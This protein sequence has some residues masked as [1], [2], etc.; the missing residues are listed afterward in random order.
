MTE[1]EAS[2]ATCDDGAVKRTHL[3]TMKMT[4]E[5]RAHLEALAT[6]DGRSAAAYIRRFVE[7]EFAALPEARAERA[8]VGR[9]RSTHGAAPRSP[10]RA[11][12]K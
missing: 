9:S 6:R 2:Y 7:T 12:R 3:F 1:G 4:D 5:E 11:T 10:K 8:N